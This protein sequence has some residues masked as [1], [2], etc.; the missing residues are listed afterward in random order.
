MLDLSVLLALMPGLQ[1]PP[2]LP[3]EHVLLLA[4]LRADF[5]SQILHIE[6]LLDV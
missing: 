4:L 3:C 1:V 2:L 6:H 5:V